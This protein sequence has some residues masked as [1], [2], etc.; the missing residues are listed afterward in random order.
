MDLDEGRRRGLEEREPT[1]GVDEDERMEPWGL[2][3]KRPSRH[4][5]H[6][7]RLYREFLEGLGDRDGDQ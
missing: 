4:I 6:K 3:D 7:L 2:R 1:Q 5:R